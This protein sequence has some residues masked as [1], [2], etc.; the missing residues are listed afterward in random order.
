MF[1]K[2]KRQSCLFFLASKASLVL[3]G[4]RELRPLRKEKGVFGQA[5]SSAGL[6]QVRSATP[7][8]SLVT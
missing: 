7:T 3:V 6:Y 5:L 1:T 2:K 8:P 4:Y